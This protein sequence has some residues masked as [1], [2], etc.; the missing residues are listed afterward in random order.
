[1]SKL[2][3]YQF[4]STIELRLAVTA[5]VIAQTHTVFVVGIVVNIAYYS[6]LVFTNKH[7]KR[8]A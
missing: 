7:F 1:M 4:A 2:C 3:P 8:F 6:L 5:T